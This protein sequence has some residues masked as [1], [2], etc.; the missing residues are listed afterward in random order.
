MKDLLEGL[1]KQL[2]SMFL[3]EELVKKGK[4][5]LIAE[6]EKLA[7]STDNQLDDAVIAILKD[8]LK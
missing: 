7:L 2:I 8:A 6:L 1:L 5:M 4:D 3:T